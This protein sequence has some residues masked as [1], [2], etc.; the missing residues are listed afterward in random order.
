MQVIDVPIVFDLD[1]SALRTVLVTVFCGCSL[2]GHDVSFPAGVRV[3]L[4]RRY[5]YL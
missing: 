1:V 3:F 2:L 5:R 4:D